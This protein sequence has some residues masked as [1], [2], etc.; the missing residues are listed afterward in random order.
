MRPN[1][2]AEG[3][4]KAKSGHAGHHEHTLDTV[5]GLVGGFP[6]GSSSLPGRTKK[7]RE[8]GVF[9][10]ETVGAVAIARLMATR[11]RQA[12]QSAHAGHTVAY[13]LMQED[14]MAEPDAAT[15]EVLGKLA[16]LAGEGS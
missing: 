2:P 10:S 11:S 14:T 1:R 16:A 13:R 15:R 6:R 5:E 7:P 4:Y 9:L 8:S 3:L 12:P